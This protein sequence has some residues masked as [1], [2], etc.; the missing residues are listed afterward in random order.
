[1]YNWPGSK[2]FIFTSQTHVMIQQTRDYYQPLQIYII[3]I[4]QKPPNY[5]IR[6]DQ[7]AIIIPHYVVLPLVK[8]YALM[9]IETH[10]YQLFV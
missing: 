4:L 10:T 9:S 8:L 5:K 6:S 1:M 3:Y 2:V 7:A